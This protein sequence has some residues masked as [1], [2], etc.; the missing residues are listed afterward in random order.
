MHAPLIPSIPVERCPNDPQIQ[1]PLSAV[2]G[3]SVSNDAWVSNGASPRR[4]N[5]SRSE[6]SHPKFI[7]RPNDFQSRSQ[8]SHPLLPHSSLF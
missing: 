6:K 3:V 5:T 7:V 2:R 8:P 1:S 4:P